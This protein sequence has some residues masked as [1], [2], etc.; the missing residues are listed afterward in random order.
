MKVCGTCGSD[1]VFW[2][3]Y[4]SVNDPND[5]RVFDQAFCDSCGETDL[6]DGV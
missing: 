3:A 2:D 4:V 1:V 6:I 5:V